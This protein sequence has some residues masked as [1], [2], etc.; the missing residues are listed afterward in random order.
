MSQTTDLTCANVLIEKEG[1]LYVFAKFWLPEAKLEEAIARDG[2]P[3]NIY[4]ERGILETS[5]ENFVDYHD[6]FNWFRMLVE[7]YEILPLQ[8][9]YDRY[10]AQYLV[11]D[12]KTYG[13]HMDDVY[14]GDNLWGVIQETEGLLKDG[15]IKIGDND[16]LKI[17]LLDTA[18]KMSLDRGRGRII[19]VNSNSHIDGVASLLDSMTVRQKWHT[20]IGEQ[21]KNV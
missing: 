19:K 21:L 5:G 14:Q 17:H 3:Y 8:I 9:G 15:K 1:T 2:V 16:L 4:K 6:C 7:E 20:E 18:I 10:S 12:M 13:F 11:Q